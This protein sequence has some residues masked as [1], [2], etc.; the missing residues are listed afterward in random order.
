VCGWPRRRQWSDLAEIK[1]AWQQV[2]LVI[3]KLHT[4]A[5]WYALLKAWI[6]QKTAC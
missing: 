6:Q 5:A 1:T 2:R 3:K 4:L